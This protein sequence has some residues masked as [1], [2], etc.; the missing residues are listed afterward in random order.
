MSR[1]VI[2]IFLCMVL[3]IVQVQF[4]GTVSASATTVQ[5]SATVCSS[6]IVSSE[7]NLKVGKEHAPKNKMLKISVAKTVW[8]VIV[9][10][11]KKIPPFVIFS[12]SIGAAIVY[13]IHLMLE[14]M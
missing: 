7:H 12:L 11:F 8:A 10:F 13:V 2:G 4:L 1:R 6:N 3:A 9:N 5:S 14:A